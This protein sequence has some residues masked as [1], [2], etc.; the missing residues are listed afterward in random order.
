MPKSTESPVKFAALTAEGRVRTV[1]TGRHTLALTR[2]AGLYAALSNHCPHQ[3][4]PLGVGI[5]EKPS[6]MTDRR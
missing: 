6:P 4:G 1:T 3:G 5:I 2:F